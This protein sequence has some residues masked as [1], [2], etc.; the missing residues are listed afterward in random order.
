MAKIRKSEV[1]AKVAFNMRKRGKA[2]GA[3]PMFNRTEVNEIR[4]AYIEEDVSVQELA[5]DY[6]TSYVTLHKVL[7]GKGPYQYAE[8]ARFG[9]EV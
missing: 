5:D 1:L 3:K 9:N 7:H 6:E 4:R 2:I 8:D